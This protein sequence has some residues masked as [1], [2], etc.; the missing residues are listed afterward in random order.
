MGIGTMAITA[1]YNAY[2]YDPYDRPYYRPGLSVG[3]G[4]FGFGLGF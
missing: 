4:P 2:G 1:G 3:V